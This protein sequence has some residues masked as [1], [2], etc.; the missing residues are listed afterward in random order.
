MEVS[1]IINNNPLI[2]ELNEI[3]EKLETNSPT[4][5]FRNCENEIYRAYGIITELKNQYSINNQYSIPQEIS[6]IINKELSYFKKAMNENKIIYLLIFFIMNDAINIKIKEVL[7]FF[8][9]TTKDKYK[10]IEMITSFI[11]SLKFVKEDIKIGNKTNY[12]SKFSSIKFIEEFALSI[13]TNKIEYSFIKYDLLDK[14]KY[15]LLDNLKRMFIYLDIYAFINFIN[16][17]YNPLKIIILLNNFNNDELIRISHYLNS[18][19]KILIFEVIKLFCMKKDNI[20]E[21]TDKIK[22][23]LNL[24]FKK[25]LKFFIKIKNNCIKNKMFIEGYVKLLSSLNDEEKVK[26]AWLP[27]KLDEYTKNYNTHL[28]YNLKENFPNFNYI[29]ELTFEEYEKYLNNF[30]PKNKFY[31]FL[32]TDYCDFINEY[33]SSYSED[34]IITEFTD[35]FNEI[36]YIYQNWFVDKSEMKQKNYL[37]LTKLWFISNIYKN[38]NLNENMVQNEIRMLFNNKIYVK[39][40]LDE[41]YMEYINEIKQNIL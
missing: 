7:S 13:I 21:N 33:Y 27:L 36:K 1:M 9:I 34:K 11:D 6:Y 4:T 18:E 2:I 39:R 29:L 10:L 15:K 5:F 17:E 22:D 41:Q 35:I 32:I 31:G 20:N 3:L 30:N 12:Y 19:N 24:I 38:K 37:L 40:F 26:K 28:F 23:L 14:Y 8:E 16:Y 25:D